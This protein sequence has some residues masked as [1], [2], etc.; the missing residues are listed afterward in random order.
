[1]KYALLSLTIIFAGCSVQGVRIPLINGAKYGYVEVGAVVAYVPPE[2][3]Y[4]T[5]PVDGKLYFAPI[6]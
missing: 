6:K 4:V 3:N 5:L 1:M 2:G